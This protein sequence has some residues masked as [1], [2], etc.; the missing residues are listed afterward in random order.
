MF[1]NEDK[2]L[3]QKPIELEQLLWHEHDWSDLEQAYLTDGARIRK[4]MPSHQPPRHVF[5]YKHRLPNGVNVEIEKD[6]PV[7]DYAALWE[8]TKERVRKRRYSIDVGQVRWDIDFPRWSNGV[9]FF[10]IAEAEM[11]IQMMHPPHILPI[12]E[13][14]IVYRVPRDDGRFAARLIGDETHARQL[15]QEFN[16]L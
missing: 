16:L 2:F 5:T 15:A 14:F 11:P 13:P 7:E 4:L 6:I 12:I 3:L 9:R 10:A 8:Y 1:E